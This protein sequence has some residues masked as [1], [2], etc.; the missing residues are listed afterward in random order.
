MNLGNIMVNERSQTPK[1]KY[2]MITFIGNFQNTESIET[3]RR[4]VVVR[5]WRS[6]GW[7]VTA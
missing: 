5:E 3:E 1:A 4:M 2:H 7:G 6:R